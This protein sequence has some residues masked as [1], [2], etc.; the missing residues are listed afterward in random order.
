MADLYALAVEAMQDPA[1]NYP[2]QPQSW[3]F[4]SYIHDVPSN[5]FDPANS[6]SITTQKDFEARVN[7]IYGNPAAGTPQANW[8]QA[9]LAC[10]ATCEHSS[11][12]FTVWHR[13]YLYLFERICRRMCNDGSF[14]LPY[15]NYAFD[16]GPSLQLP[17]KFRNPAASPSG[18]RQQPSRL[19]FHDRG[20]GYDNPGGRGARNTAMNDGGYMPYPDIAYGHAFETNVMFPADISSVDPSDPAYMKL[21]FTG[22]L[23]IVPH[24]MVHDSIG[25]WMANPSAAAGD[26]IFYVHH[27]QIDRLIA[28]WEAQKGVSYNWGNDAGSP[29]Q[30]TWANRTAAFVDENGKLGSA[31]LASATSIDAFGYG[32]DNLVNRQRIAVATRSLP[33]LSG[34]KPVELVAMRADGFNVGAGGSTVALAP[35]P[36]ATAAAIAHSRPAI[37]VLEGI[38]LLQRPPAPL[39]VFIN[40]P[41]GTAPELNSPYYVGKLNLFKFNLGTGG[42]LMHHNATRGMAM[43]R[44]DARFDVTDILLSQHATGL[45]D[46]GAVTITISTIGADS[47]GDATYLTVASATLTP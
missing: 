1:I 43:G 7:Q 20:L 3:T 30:Q 22:R 23:E 37:L 35:Q 47:P 10:W 33:I 45:W 46:G 8:K 15:W 31:K 9:A 40:L 16:N 42:L 18:Q 24:D 38:K 25:G 39:S 2:P 29:P 27:C 41:K 6:G 32:Y 21:G 4:Q 14:M 11:A 5:P 26:P 36:G 28:S 17:A 13:W 19:V 12:Y 34:A 44:P